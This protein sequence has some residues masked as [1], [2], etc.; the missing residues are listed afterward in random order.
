MLPFHPPFINLATKSCHSARL[1]DAAWY[2]KRWMG[3][4]RAFLFD[5]NTFGALVV[6]EYT[7][8]LGFPSL[9]TRLESQFLHEW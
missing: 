5:T 3:F 4:K 7:D 2:E 8:G 1:L 6:R 9:S